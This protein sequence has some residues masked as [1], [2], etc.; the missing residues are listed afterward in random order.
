MRGAENRRNHAGE[1]VAQF[2]EDE[3]QKEGFVS[4]HAEKE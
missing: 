2:W 3:N 4:L 1:G